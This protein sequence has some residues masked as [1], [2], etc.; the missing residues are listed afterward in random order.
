MRSAHA[1]SRPGSAVTSR[2]SSGT[3]T[4]AAPE[5]RSASDR[6]STAH[7][8]SSSS[9]TVSASTNVAPTA[10]A[11]AGPRHIPSAS[12]SDAR[13][14]VGC[15]RSSS[16]PAVRHEL[17]ETERVHV[18][19]VHVEPIA[20]G[21]GDEELAKTCQRSAQ[22]HD[23]GLHRLGRA[24][25]GIIRP[26]DVDDGVHRGR[27]S[28]G[29]LARNAS[30]RRRWV[31]A[32]WTGRPSCSIVS[33]PSTW[34]RTP[35][36]SFAVAPRTRAISSSM[37]VPRGCNP[38]AW[39]V[40]GTIRGRALVNGRR[41]GDLPHRLPAVQPITGV[42][43]HY[44][45]GDHEFIPTLLGVRPDGRPWAEL[46]LGT[47]PTGPA[48]LTDGRPL[49]DVTGP[50]PYLLKVLAAAEPLSL[51]AHPSRRA[52]ANGVRRRSLPRPRAE[53][54]AALRADRLRG[55]L[56]R[57]S[58]RRHARTARRA[59]CR[60]AGGDPRAITAPAR[61]WLRC[62]AAGLHV[63]PIVAAAATSDRPEAVWVRRLAER[64]PGDPSVAAT[65][66]LNLV[67]P[68]PGRGDPARPR[69]PPRLP[70]R[71]RHRADGG[72]RQRRARRPHG[73]GGRRRRPPRR[74]RPDATR[75][76]GADR[77]R[78]ARPRRARRSA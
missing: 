30:S 48:T 74:R 42:V 9:R 31:P 44:A 15:P 21:H 11:Y 22:P 33:G 78:R 13:A 76:P 35:G 70:R 26:Q 69:Q 41:A 63:D 71:R 20:P 24:R 14:D 2:S 6:S 19:W 10:S 50:L 12:A 43:Q 66:L 45:W 39:A 52:G 54:G 47:H 53:A 37:A 18:R 51:Q 75:G 68:A 72:E 25:W 46:W 62:T 34:T 64:Y 23:V 49:A 55:V 29:R 61:R 67:Q 77:R 73:E 32:M 38:V 28:P 58:R 7:R 57:P 36:R 8:R 3:A 60:R 40:A 27:R 56:W 17:L 1:R 4:A 5:T 16:A 59:R 65:L